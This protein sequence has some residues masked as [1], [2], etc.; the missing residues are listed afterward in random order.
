MMLS[1]LCE[2]EI[3]FIFYISLIEF[4]VNY[5][6]SKNKQLTMNKNNYSK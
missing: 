6:M 2:G 3:M 4:E 5:L 1:R